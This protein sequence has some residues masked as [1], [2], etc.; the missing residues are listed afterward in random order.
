MSDEQRDFTKEF[1]KYK[2]QKIN[3]LSLSTFPTTVNLETPEGKQQMLSSTGISKLE[4]VAMH[5]LSSQI[6]FNGFNSVDD[7]LIKKSFHNAGIFLA[8]HE[9]IMAKANEFAKNE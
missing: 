2:A 9:E 4:L 3:Q 1:E 8:M 7:D 5:L 6:A